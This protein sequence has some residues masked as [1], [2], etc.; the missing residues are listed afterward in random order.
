MERVSLLVPVSVTF[1]S[2]VSVT[3]VEKSPGRVPAVKSTVPAVKLRT[4]CTPLVG[5]R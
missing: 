5:T 1:P 2:K 3:G 4:D